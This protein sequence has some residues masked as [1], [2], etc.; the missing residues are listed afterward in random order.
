MYTVGHVNR[1]HSDP[2]GATPLSE[3]RYL[4]FA[5]FEYFTGTQEVS[6]NASFVGCFF[7]TNLV[8]HLNIEWKVQGG[9]GSV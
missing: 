4:L 9:L 5:T 3:Q 2:T 7:C 8:S 6:A 1:A